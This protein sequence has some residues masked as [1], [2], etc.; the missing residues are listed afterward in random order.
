MINKR[1]EER[2]FSG[3]D[4]VLSDYE[5]GQVAVSDVLSVHRIATD[6]DYFSRI[7]SLFLFR[8]A[9][10]SLLGDV[11]ILDYYRDQKVSEELFD[12]LNA[13]YRQNGFTIPNRTR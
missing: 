12:E 2:S 1:A 10:V 7:D 4:A 8:A 9:F 3:F 6:K 5:Q 11:G 13:L